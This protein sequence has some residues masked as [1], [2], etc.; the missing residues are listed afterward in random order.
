[1]TF[2]TSLGRTRTISVPNPHAG[3]N[4]AG[5]NE[6]AGMFITANPF[7]AETG[8]LV[9][10]LRASRVTVTRQTIVAAPSA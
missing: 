3:L 1:M 7:N 2:S 8:A 4:A 10:L 5:V 6:A 9:N